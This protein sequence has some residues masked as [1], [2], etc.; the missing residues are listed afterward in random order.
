MLLHDRVTI[1]EQI[2][3]GEHDA[4]GRPI[5]ETV[6]HRM[7]AQVDPSTTETGQED[8]GQIITRFRVMFMPPASLDLAT[9][10]EVNW[11]GRTL[12]PDGA[13]MPVMLRGR[14]HHHEF[15]TEQITG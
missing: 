8:S 11:R 9:L 15:T 13:I 3:T 6:E 2:P 5:Y 12:R 1:S 7:P 4:A 14:V 10:G